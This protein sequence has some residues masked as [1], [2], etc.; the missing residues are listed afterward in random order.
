MTDQQVCSIPFSRLLQMSKIISHYKKKE[1]QSFWSK[2][3][4]VGWQYYILQPKGKGAKTLSFN[5][6]LNDF[7]IVEKKKNKIYSKDAE[8]DRKRALDNASK[9]MAAFGRRKTGG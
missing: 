4:F 9:V 6:W 2:A 3:A 8:K 1:E 7:G 5:E